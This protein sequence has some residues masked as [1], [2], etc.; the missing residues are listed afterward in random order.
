MTHQTGLNESEKVSKYIFSH[1]SSSCSSSRPTSR[2]IFT[3]S[4]SNNAKRK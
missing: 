1:G 2:D 3:L 4:I